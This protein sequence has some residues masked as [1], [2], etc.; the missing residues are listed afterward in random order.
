MTIDAPIS[1]RPSGKTGA[2]ES[3]EPRLMLSMFR[4]AAPVPAPAEW[5]GTS[6]LTAW[7]MDGNAEL[8][9]CGAAVTDHG[10]VAKAGN[11]S[12]I[13]TLG[14]SKFGGTVPTYYAYG[15]AMGEPTEPGAAGPDQGV[16]NASWCKFCFDNGLFDGY[17]EIPLAEAPQY[18]WEL[19]GVI[20]AVT[21]TGDDQRKFGAHETWTVTDGSTPDPEMGHDMLLIGFD[22][23]GRW[24]F[25]TWGGL[26]WADASWVAACVTDVWGFM[27]ENDANRTGHDWASLKAA[28]A[29]VGGTTD[30]V[31]PPPP[32]VT[33][34]APIVPVPDPIVPPAPEIVP[35]A[36]VE[37]PAPAE[38]W[39]D[40]LLD[41]LKELVEDGVAQIEADRRNTP[42][43]VAHLVECVGSLKGLIDL[44]KHL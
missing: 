12:L 40:R 3:H 10:N 25:V 24:L 30:D 44:L 32:S 18:A 42:S 11:P 20:V 28:I 35:P 19:G 14:A 5:D 39:E 38:S 27:D 9:D 1:S 22:S 34:P 36:P 37:P 4:T 2:R 29:A 23:A 6:G 16:D 31:T 41:Q 7:G 13:G 8:E 21:L 43:I 15:R 26:Q 33:P 17:G